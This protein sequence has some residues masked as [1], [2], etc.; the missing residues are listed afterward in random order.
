MS[1]WPG[2]CRIVFTE[3]LNIP[4]KQ[5]Q[6][7]SQESLGNQ[8]VPASIGVEETGPR[9]GQD[10]D[11]ITVLSARPGWR[12]GEAASLLGA[13]CCGQNHRNAGP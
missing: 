6:G 13:G 4:W 10:G 3:T 9:S 1:G 11:G 2:A 5:L 12:A 8:T 7:V